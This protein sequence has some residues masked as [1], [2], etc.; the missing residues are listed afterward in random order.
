MGTDWQGNFLL[1][2][3]H[4]GPII[5]PPRLA[6][7]PTTREVPELGAWRIQQ[8]VEGENILKMQCI[9]SN[10]KTYRNL[11]VRGQAPAGGDRP[12]YRG[13]S[14]IVGEA[15]GRY[16]DR[17]RYILTPAEQPLGGLQPEARK[18]AEWERQWSDATFLEAHVTVQGWL[19]DGH[20][21]WMA[22]DEVVVWSPMAI[23]N[24]MLKIQTVTFRQDR[25]SGTT[26]TLHLRLPWGLNDQRQNLAVQNEIHYIPANQYP[27]PTAAPT[28]PTTP[29]ADPDP[30]P[31]KVPARPEETEEEKAARIKRENEE[32]QDIHSGIQFP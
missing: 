17:Y 4:E 22:G 31:S 27:A 30:D 24:E 18:R 19:R 1:I 21:L 13:A 14:E 8:L 15:V 26:T 29:A 11:E 12:A 7:F 25:N 32:N 16:L 3:K 10:D 2:G 20:N 5:P 6:D 28:T 23:L 9:I